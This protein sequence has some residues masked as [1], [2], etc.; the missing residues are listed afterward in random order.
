MRR[1]ERIIVYVCGDPTIDP[2]V[3]RGR[4][5]ARRTGATLTIAVAL[6]GSGKAGQRRVGTIIRSAAALVRSAAAR[7]RRAARLLPHTPALPDRSTNATIGLLGAPPEQLARI[8][9]RDSHDLLLTSNRDHAIALLRTCPCAVC[10]VPDRREPAG[11]APPRAL[12][13]S[14]VS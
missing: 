4:A 11:C 13:E 10:V 8:V 5:L 1:F 2:A 14:I 7:I 6:G 12:A 9:L 3:E